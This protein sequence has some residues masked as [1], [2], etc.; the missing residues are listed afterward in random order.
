MHLSW[1]ACL[2]LAKQ[3]A[4]GLTLLLHHWQSSTTRFSESDIVNSSMLRNSFML[5]HT[6]SINECI[7]NRKYLC[8]RHCCR[9]PLRCYLVKSYLC[10]LG[11]KAS[12]KRNVYSNVHPATNLHV[13]IRKKLPLDII[14]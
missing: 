2:A 3:E 6:A 9:R 13:E 12:R 7:K 1:I 5:L 11:N 4:L 8:Q 14:L 10:E